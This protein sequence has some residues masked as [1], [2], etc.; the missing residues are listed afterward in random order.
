MFVGESSQLTGSICWW[1][2]PDGTPPNQFDQTFLSATNML[3]VLEE[4]ASKQS[5][6]RAAEEYLLRGVAKMIEWARSGAVTVEAKIGIVSE[7]S[8]QIAALN[9]WT[10]TWS[11]VSDYYKTSE[12]HSIARACSRN[13]D[14]MHF[15]YSMNWIADVAG[16]Q[17]I[18]Y[19]AKQRKE[20]FRVGYE[21]MDILYQGTHFESVFRFPPPGTPMN[22]ASYALAMRWHGV[23]IDNFFEIARREGPCQVGNVENAVFNPLSTT[24]NTTLFFTFTY[25][26]EIKL[27][28]QCDDNRCGSMEDVKA[29][30]W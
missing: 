17:I 16:S 15:A 7:L 18:D 5:F 9:P 30:G 23:W 11:N 8:P 22:I 25:D 26:P 13:G 1:D 14:S 6:F 10:M 12:F 21:T 27:K 24:G 28:P 29:V 4:R 2:C 20:I 19:D 3:L